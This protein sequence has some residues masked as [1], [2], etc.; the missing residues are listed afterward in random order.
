MFDSEPQLR[1]G[2]DA[3]FRYIYDSVRLVVC[4]L[5][6]MGL[7]IYSI[8]LVYA[9]ALFIPRALLLC[10]QDV[11]TKRLLHWAT[12]SCS[13]SGL[14]K[15]PSVKL[16]RS[17]MASHLPRLSSKYEPPDLELLL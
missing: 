3:V 16:L 5:R 17:Q 10:Q 6:W 13:L 4:R 2:G 9:R 11:S 12:G 14:A 7:Y 1:T 15:L 8:E